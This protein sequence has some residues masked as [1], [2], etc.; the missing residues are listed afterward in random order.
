MCG[1]GNVV[2]DEGLFVVADVTEIGVVK[3]GAHPR[4]LPKDNP[5]P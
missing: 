3:C 4:S 1:S 2:S 5:N